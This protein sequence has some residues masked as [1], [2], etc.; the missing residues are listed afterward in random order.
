[1]MLL[2]NIEC[3]CCNNSRASLVKQICPADNICLNYHFPPDNIIIL[4]PRAI[5]YIL[6]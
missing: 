4:P 1:M 3:H 2:N 5:I 6:A